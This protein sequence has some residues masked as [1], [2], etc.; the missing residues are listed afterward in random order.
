MKKLW[1][2]HAVEYYSTMKKKE[3]LPFGIT[4]MDLEGIMLLEIIQIKKNNTVQYHLYMKSKIKINTVQ[5]HLHMKFK[6]KE[7]Q[8]PGSQTQRTDWWF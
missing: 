6:N 7:T 3:F 4:W 8:K 2:I 1:H 5:F